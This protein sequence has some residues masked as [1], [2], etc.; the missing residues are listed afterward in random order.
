MSSK[1]GVWMRRLAL[2]SQVCAQQ[3]PLPPQVC[4]QQVPPQPPLLRGLSLRPQRGRALAGGGLLPP[5]QHPRPHFANDTLLVSGEPLPRTC[6][7]S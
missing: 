1:G 4:A 7:A 3:V 5:L 2:P 6:S